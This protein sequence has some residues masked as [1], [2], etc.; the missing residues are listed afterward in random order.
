MGLYKEILNK[1][2]FDYVEDRAIK[3]IKS[4]FENESELISKSVK[5]YIY[6]VHYRYTT[7]RGNLKTASKV[8]VIPDSDIGAAKAEVIEY[9]NEHNKQFP[10]RML[11]NVKILDVLPEELV[12]SL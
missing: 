7:K 6:K 9:I 1:Q 3:S 4:L 8:V 12:I 10:Y 11:S 5:V 2:T